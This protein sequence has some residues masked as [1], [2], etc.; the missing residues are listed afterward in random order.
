[1]QQL[2]SSKGSVDDRLAAAD[3]VPTQHAG[4]HCNVVDPSLLYLKFLNLK[5]IQKSTQI[6]VFC[7]GINL[8]LQL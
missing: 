5:M 3:R 7:G 6:W 1:V 4:E 2:F 8:P